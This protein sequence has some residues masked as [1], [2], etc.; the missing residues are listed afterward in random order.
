MIQSLQTEM[1]GVAEETGLTSD[2]AVMDLVK[3]VRSEKGV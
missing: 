1:A 3:E 2:E